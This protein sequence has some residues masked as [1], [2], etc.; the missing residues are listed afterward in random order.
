[1]APSK[2]KTRKAI[3]ILLIIS[4]IF[5]L[6]IIAG[7][8][9][10]YSLKDVSPTD[11]SANKSYC[12]CYY[13]DPL[14]TNSC[15]DSR[16]GFNF[17]L[18]SASSAEECDPQCSTSSLEVSKLNST[19]EQADYI[20]CSVPNISDERCTQMI[21]EDQDG[22][23]VTGKVYRTDT[24]TV[25]AVFDDIYTPYKFYINNEPAD[26]D[27]I[28]VEQKTVTKTINVSDYAT[29]S[30]LEIKAS[31]TDS[32]EEMINSEACH[33]LIE[34]IDEGEIS[35]SR[36]AFETETDDDSVGYR[37]KTALID[38]GNLTSADG[39]EV[40]FSFD[41]SSIPDLTITEGLSVN[42]S[43]GR[44]TIQEADLYLA[45]NFTDGKSF[46]L[47]EDVTG[48]LVITAEVFQ[49][50]ASLGTA[51]TTLE[52]PIP[53]EDGTDTTDTDTTDT[54]TNENSSFSVV[55]TVSPS[56]VERV[57]GSNLAT[58]TITIHNSEEVSDDITSILDKLPFGFVYVEESSKINGQSVSD[59]DY[60]TV[61]TTGNSQEIT[62]EAENGWSIPSENDMIIV[63]SAT[64]GENAITGANQNEVVVTPVNTP[65]DP[66]ALRAEAVV[67]V[68]QDCTSP[69]TGIL[70]TS[71]A[72]IL[73]GL[74]II[75]TG[76][77]MY[78]SPR[79]TLLAEAVTRTSPYKTAK[80]AGIRMFR[81]R[82]YF[83]TKVMEKI[84]KRKKNN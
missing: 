37:Y 82:E 57:S 40:T 22:K 72:K 69:D 30:S 42:L 15:G 59:D 67:T 21:V 13:L 54:T 63:F 53:D 58:F 3:K 46:E 32:S 64:A 68:A 56:C 25:T 9:Y 23:T 77:F 79:A 19:T 28:S 26:A 43:S 80:R 47:L 29:S 49:D 74:L 34:I 66:S 83:E 45:D 6:L 36:L 20:V 4:G 84:E 16:L 11:T 61:E 1:M 12:G 18:Y 50:D 55:K 39:I 24:L 73:I 2:R 78:S 14:V 44:I 51:K 7:A 65:N 81:P 33:R 38:V 62:W 60:V 27:S 8:V 71:I 75:S 76:Y 35:V 17:S 41:R 5:G 10:F 52:I 31:G 70:D 48:D